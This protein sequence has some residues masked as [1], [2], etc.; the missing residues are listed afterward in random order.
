MLLSE[1]V[2]SI[3]N[4]DTGEDPDIIFITNT[5]EYANINE[6]GVQV[7]FY[8]KSDY[9]SESMLTGEKLNDGNEVIV[10]VGC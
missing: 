3:R 2:K 10:E 6:G 7:E 8:K 1:F 4:K 9:Y 5:S